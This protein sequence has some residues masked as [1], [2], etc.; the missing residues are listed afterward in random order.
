MAMM[1]RRFAVLSLAVSIVALSACAKKDTD[2]TVPK[3]STVSVPAESSTLSVSTQA[4][5]PTTH[6]IRTHEFIRSTESG[7]KT[8]VTVDVSGDAYI[9]DMHTPPVNDKLIARFSNVGYPGYAK[10]KEKLYGFDTKD[11]VDEYRLYIRAAKDPKTGTTAWELMRWTAADNKEVHHRGGGLKLCEPYHQTGNPDVG[12]K[13]CALI[14]P[15]PK[16]NHAS[17]F[18]TGVLEALYARMFGLI[19]PDTIIRLTG[20]AWVSCGDGCCSVSQ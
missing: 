12:F 10:G 16:S 1:P 7:G 4:Q 9:V 14:P 17:M 6:W 19:Q 15:Q 13:D 8:K 3:D 20:P 2:D 18:G 11:K 5:Q